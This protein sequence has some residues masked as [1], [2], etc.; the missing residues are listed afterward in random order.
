MDMSIS[1]N[2][3]AIVFDDHKMFAD[4]F[5]ALIERAEMFQSVFVFQEERDLI[6]F[7]IQLSTSVDIYLF[8]DY[9]LK[10]KHALPIIND[11]KRICKQLK[12]ILVSSVSDPVCI[13]NILL[14]NPD[15]FLSKSSGFIETL[16]CIK[17]IEANGKF[18]SPFI[19]DILRL[20]VKGTISPFTVREIEILQ[21]FDQGFSNLDT[22]EKL[23]LSKHTVIAHR[24]HMMQ[25]ASCKTIV[26]L[27]AF[28]RKRGII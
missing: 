4:S 14:H 16:E 9:Y 17:A 19:S 20:A 18:L 3:I 22:A 11:A 27:L 25:K 8:V 12:V 2:S 13:Q 21:H 15:G 23:Y 10:D 24:R 1:I 26:E 5:A 28:S 7:L 6:Q